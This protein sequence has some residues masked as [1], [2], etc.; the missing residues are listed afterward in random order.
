[1]GSSWILSALGCLGKVWRT[2]NLWVGLPWLRVAFSVQA[3]RYFIWVTTW[4]RTASTKRWRSSH[5]LWSCSDTGFP[6]HL[7]HLGNWALTL[8]Q[9][10]GLQTPAWVEAVAPWN[11]LSLCSSFSAQ[12]GTSC[13]DMRFHWREFLLAAVSLI[14]SRQVVNWLVTNSVLS[15][16]LQPHWPV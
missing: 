1:M 9:Q 16:L 7:W 14:H 12:K 13:L 5:D 6:Q 8:L 4:T 11:I 2:C 10:L 3:H 15:L